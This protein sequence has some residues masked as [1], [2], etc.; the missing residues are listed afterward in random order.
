MKNVFL[1]VLLSLSLAS[2]SYGQG[3]SWVLVGDSDR[4]PA[5]RKLSRALSLINDFYVDSI[6]KNKMADEA[7]ISLLQKLD[8]HSEY[9]TAEEIKA[10]SEPL[11]GNFEGIGI[12]FNMLTDTLYVVQV[13][14]GGPSEKVGL[15]AGDRIITVNDTLI[16][17]VGMKNPDILKRLRGKKGTIV[18][19]QV[20]RG[21]ELIPFAIV[22]DKIPIYSLDA[23]YMLDEETGYIALNRFGETTYSEFMK[24]LRELQDQGMKNLILDLQNNGGGYLNVPV[25]IA[26]EFLKRGNLIVY[27]EGVNQR[28]R[29]D[30][31]S[32]NGS[33]EDGKLVVL[34]NQSSAS[35][36][37]IL[38]GAIQDWDRGVIVG[39][40]SFGKGMVQSVRPLPDGSAIK[41]TTAHYYTPSGRSIQKPYEKGNRKEYDMDVMNRYNRG[42]MM[43]ADSIHF[44]DSLKY[45][46]L[47]NKRTVYGGGG[48]MPDYFVPLDTV[49][50][51]NIYGALAASGSIAKIAMNYIDNNRAALKAKYPDFAAFKSNFNV[52]DELLK[53]L[54]RLYEAESKNAKSTQTPVVPEGDLDVDP[55]EQDYLF[56]E[57]LV[58]DDQKTLRDFQKSA[59]FIKLQIKALIAR[60]LWDMNEYYQI[61]NQDNNVLKKAI[62]IIKDTKEYNKLLGNK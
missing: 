27:T 47:V 56:P 21:N 55:E 7:I 41:L 17:G 11:Q 5:S 62:E 14:S 54:L 28:R 19:I 23:S 8:P 36:S 37:E 20:K 15:L 24:A 43:S 57:E 6:N 38:C 34:I 58:I 60:D 48:I 35:A 12:Q 51:T 3:P 61:I 44:P 2:C 4:D 32:S 1:S 39:R 42:E 59:P 18:R 30:Y 10:M 13:I 40:R 53:E 16:A 9:L 45:T 25:D 50:Y 26:N 46:T 31:A 49:Y 29:D 52:S 22:R 33:F